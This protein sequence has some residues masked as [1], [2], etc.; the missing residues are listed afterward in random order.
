MKPI[1]GLVTP[2]PLL[3]SASAFTRDAHGTTNTAQLLASAT[4]VLMITI[5]GLPLFMPALTAP[6]KFRSILMQS[7]TINCVTRVLWLVAGYS[8]TTNAALTAKTAYS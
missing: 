4:L 7:F 5:P 1:I 2:L 3:F 8:L 6:K